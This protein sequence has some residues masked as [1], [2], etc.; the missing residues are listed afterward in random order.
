[1]RADL[2]VQTTALASTGPANCITARRSYISISFSLRDP[3]E[4]NVCMCVFISFF[5]TQQI[6]N[7]ENIVYYVVTAKT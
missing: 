6:F 5:Y 3:G 7:I 1:M 2:S 4:K